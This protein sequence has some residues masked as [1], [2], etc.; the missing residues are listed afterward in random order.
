[1][2]RLLILG[3]TAFLGRHVVA[4]ACDAGHAVAVFNRGITGPA[5]PDGVER[6]VG[7]RDGDLAALAQRRFDAV[8]DCSGY[9]PQQLSASGKALADGIAHYVFVSTRSVY[10]SLAPDARAQAGSPVLEGHEGYGALKARSEEAIVATLP[11]RVTIARPG[12]IVG[13]FDP[14][15][16]FTYWP[17]RVARGGPILAPGRPERPVQWIDARDF[18]AWL[19]SIAGRAP[20][21]GDGAILDVVGPSMTMGTLL[22]AI[23]ATTGS[24]ARFHWM[25]DDA[26]LA[27][28][29]V[30][31]TE[32]PLWIPERDPRFGGLMRGTDDR[33]TDAGLT[34][35]PIG[36]TIAATLAWALGPGARTPQAVATMTAAREA[37]LLGSL[38]SLCSLSGPAGSP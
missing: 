1:M 29:V 19:V 37:D 6:L 2:M 7:D 9:T 8:I 10:R 11:G 5:P 31:W 27:H 32:L 18:A 12:L 17:L 38:S 22:D 28:A 35:R 21:A 26:L 33:A 3:G 24:D 15:G 25:S 16:R 20:S 23:R 13:P 36:E 30:P 4:A 14:T 34:K